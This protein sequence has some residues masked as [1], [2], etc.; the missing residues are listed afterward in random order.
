MSY[1]FESWCILQFVLAYSVTHTKIKTPRKA[2]QRLNFLDFATH[3][4]VADIVIVGQWV[5]STWVGY[6]YFGFGCSS[7]FHPNQWYN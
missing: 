6:W 5:D 1:L 3:H 4:H 2:Q 7:A